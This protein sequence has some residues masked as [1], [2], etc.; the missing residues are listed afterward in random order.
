MPVE[1]R[2][3]W[4]QQAAVLLL[5]SLLVQFLGSLLLNRVSGNKQI[6]TA[7]LESILYLLTALAAQRM[8]NGEKHRWI[9]SIIAG[10]GAVWAW[11]KL[12]IMP[13]DT[14]RGITANLLFLAI[15]LL[16]Q[17]EFD[18][19]C[20]RIQVSNATRRLGQG[21]RIFLSIGRLSSIAGYLLMDAKLQG[22][23]VTADS[24]TPAMQIGVW[25]EVLAMLATLLS[26][27]YQVRYL[28]RI[29]SLFLTR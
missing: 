10:I 9:P 16:M 21:W 11:C 7:I 26:Y 28:W 25:V 2:N 24:L 14:V 19:E 27:I 8:Q 12:F 22:G 6:A 20:V 13:S 1:N 4:I 5:V 18:A 17:L 15:Y 23:M 3:R 29:K